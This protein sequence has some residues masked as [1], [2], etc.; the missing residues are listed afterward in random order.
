M[1]SNNFQRS[2][3]HEEPA[4]GEGQWSPQFETSSQES[5][6]QLKEMLP[7]L[8]VRWHWLLLGALLGLSWGFYKAW[9]AIPLYQAQAT[10]LVRDYSVS[11]LQ[12][13]DAAE[14]D[15]RNSAALETVR[16]GLMKYELCERV[17]SEPKVRALD[18]LVPPSPKKLFESKSEKAMEPVE[19]P[20]APQL[21]S[22]IR[23]WLSVNLQ[24]DS[25]L[26]SIGVTH[27]EPK[28]AATIANSIVDEYIEQRGEVKELGKNKNFDLLKAQSDRLTNE[29]SQSKTKLAIY[30]TPNKAELA[31]ATAEQELNAIKLRYR[32]KHPKYIEGSRKVEQAMGSL[33]AS[34][35]RVIVN[36][37]DSEFWSE[38]SVLVESQENKGGLDALREKLIER[39]A[40]LETEI[41]SQSSI[42]G[43]L[44]T[45]VETT[46]INKEQNEAEVVSYE[47]ARPGG[48]PITEAKTR[49][50][51]KSSLF[52]LAAG[53]ALAILFHL[54]DNKFHTVAEVES[55]LSLPVLAAVP[56]M[57]ERDLKKLKGE[58]ISGRESWMP[59][60]IFSREDTETVTAEAFRVLRATVSLLGPV[61]ER[62]STMFTSALPSEGKTT[63]ASNFAC[64]MAHQGLKVVLL[65]LDLRKPSVHKIFGREKDETKGVVD[66]LSGNA[67]P[68]EVLITDA[69]HKNLDLILSGPK[70]PNPGEL[71]ES[72]RLRKLLTLLEKNYDHVIIDSAPVLAV[73]DSRIIAPLADNFCFVLRA[74][75]TPKGAVQRALELIASTGK[76]PSG[77]VFNDFQ[78]K[79]F[80]VGK[81]YSY[82]YY[83]GGKYS[84]GSYGKVYGSG[85]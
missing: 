6:L 38:N 47:K 13:S 71:L 72:S 33:K 16:A 57:K 5:V 18:G 3:G 50:I 59:T 9:K 32:K 12:T 37:T 23:S 8:L 81:N 4:K 58:A 55:K 78:E 60:L 61:E 46:E 63:V 17:A 79:R 21:A 28:V 22:M 1:N 64:A 70:A 68:S 49:V 74:E 40:Q 66:I 41:E 24:G 67:K 10:V 76:N 7:L 45:Q 26:M 62:K 29:L 65:D 2:N 44:L 36:P 82:G 77:I 43:T 39:R 69:G 83:Q 42:S 54:L 14:F 27:P 19:A 35:G 80:M 85:K 84:Y 53:I 51:I 31:L 48:G 73:A 25:R 56:A 15:L 34:L 30:A 75:Q 20:P 52:G 11:V